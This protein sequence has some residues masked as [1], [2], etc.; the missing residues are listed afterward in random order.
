[1]Q[2]RWCHLSGS[3]ALDDDER[4]TLRISEGGPEANIINESGLYSLVIRSNKPEAKAFKRWITH[5]VLPAI[6]QYGMYAVDKLLDDPDVAIR[7]F[8]ALKEE[9]AARLKLEAENT[10]TLPKAQFYDQVKDTQRLL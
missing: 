3:T 7:A 4:T 10:K 9:R 2:A 5:E 6:H 1:M 8:T